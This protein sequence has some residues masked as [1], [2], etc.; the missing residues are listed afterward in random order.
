[1]EVGWQ[2]EKDILPSSLLAELLKV[3]CV[4]SLLKRA[5]SWGPTWTQWESLRATCFCVCVCVCV[6]VF[7]AKAWLTLVP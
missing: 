6:C 5:D 3:Q 1:M 4:G 2:G 7:F